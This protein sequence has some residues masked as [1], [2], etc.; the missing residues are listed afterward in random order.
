[1][2]FFL[3]DDSFEQVSDRL[4]RIADA[5]KK[6]F[7]LFQLR[8]MQ[9]EVSSSEETLLLKLYVDDLKQE[10]EDEKQEKKDKD[11]DQKIQS[12]PLVQ[13]V[14]TDSPQTIRNLIKMTQSFSE[15]G[16]GSFN[17]KRVLKSEDEEKSPKLLKIS[18]SVPFNGTEKSESNTSLNQLSSSTYPSS[19]SCSFNTKIEPKQTNEE[20]ED[21][22]TNGNLDDFDDDNSNDNSNEYDQFETFRP[23][24]SNQN[25]LGINE[26]N[27]DSGLNTLTNFDDFIIN[28]DDLPMSS[29]L[30]F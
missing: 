13:L 8:S 12:R 29:I 22:F 3:V 25:V 14:K 15:A 26:E 30:D 1:M 28:E 10:L 18:D 21:T 24:N 2:F 17:L 7:N 11:Q 4:L 27:S 19:S 9:K 5:M 23:L 6:R 16:S 20:F